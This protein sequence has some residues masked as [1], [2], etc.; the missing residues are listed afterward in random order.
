LAVFSHTSEK[1]TAVAGPLGG[2]G[3]GKGDMFVD[4][5]EVNSGKQ[6]LSA[7]A[8]HRGGDQPSL[9]F[10]TALWVNNSYLVVPLDVDPNDQ[11]LSVGDRVLLVI[12]PNR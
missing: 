8:P 3:P 6:I 2:G 9:Y 7:H 11:T 12:V 10:D 1:N 4:V 5:Y